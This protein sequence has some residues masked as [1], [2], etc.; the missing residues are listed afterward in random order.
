VPADSFAISI[1]AFGGKFPLR[2]FQFLIMNGIVVITDLRTVFGSRAPADHV[3]NK[4]LLILRSLP[5]DGKVVFVIPQLLRLMIPGLGQNGH[6]QLAPFFRWSQRVPAPNRND[7]RTRGVPVVKY[8]GVI[9]Q[10]D[11][12]LTK[13]MVCNVSRENSKTDMLTY[14]VSVVTTYEKLGP[15]NSSSSSCTHKT[16]S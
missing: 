15:L 3:T 10:K 11:C 16:E 4:T 7:E 9:A 8:G 14:P 6:F 5:R 1:T 13:N 12:P 2:W